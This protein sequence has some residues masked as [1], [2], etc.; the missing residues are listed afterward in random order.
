MISNRVGAAMLAAPIIGHDA[1]FTL[2]SVYSFGIFPVTTIQN[3]FKFSLPKHELI[4][5]VVKSIHVLGS[6]EVRAQFFL[7]FI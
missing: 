1:M 5:W 4:A 2:F 6:L 7:L 3:N